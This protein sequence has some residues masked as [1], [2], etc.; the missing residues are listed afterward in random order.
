MNDIEKLAEVN[1]DI[2]RLEEEQVIAQFILY[3]A[4]RSMMVCTR[5]GKLVMP[6]VLKLHTDSFLDGRGGS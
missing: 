5:D 2:K 4:D 6:S 3:L 1:K